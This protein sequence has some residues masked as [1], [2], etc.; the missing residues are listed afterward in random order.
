MAHDS[1]VTVR[2]S[3]PDSIVLDSPIATSTIDTNQTTPTK[4]PDGDRPDTPI[5]RKSSLLV[6]DTYD[7]DDKDDSL[8]DESKTLI[9]EDVVDTEALRSSSATM[10]PPILTTRSVQ[11]ELADDGNIS[12]DQDE[13]NWAQ[14][15]QKEDEQTKDE[16]TDNVSSGT[17]T[18]RILK[19]IRVVNCIVVGPT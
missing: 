7:K 18:V 19:L 4:D 6:V 3:E 12:D 11:D 8:D 5:S 10:P 9:K 13:V 14:L 1:L 2:L 17:S 16:E 15:E